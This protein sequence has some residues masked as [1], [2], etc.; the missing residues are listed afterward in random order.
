M[1]FSLHIYRKHNHTMKLTNIKDAYGAKFKVFPRKLKPM[2][3]GL[4]DYLAPTNQTLQ[5]VDVAG[6]GDC[7]AHVLGIASFFVLHQIRDFREIREAICVSLNQCDT[8]TEQ[9]RAQHCAYVPNKW[10]SESELA[11]YI[12]AV[13][14][15]NMLIITEN[16]NDKTGDLSYN[17]YLPSHV[18]DENKNFLIAYNSNGGMHWEIVV[19]RQRRTDTLTPTFTIDEIMALAGDEYMALQAQEGVYDICTQLR[20]TFEDE[21]QTGVQEIDREPKANKRK[22]GDPKTKPKRDGQA[23]DDAEG[24]ANEALQAQA[25]EGL[26]Q[27]LEEEAAERRRISAER[28]RRAESDERRRAHA[29]AERRARES[30]ERRV[31]VYAE[32]A[33]Q[34]KKKKTNRFSALNR[35]PTS[36]E[37]AAQR[38]SDEREGRRQADLEEERQRQEDEE[39]GRAQDELQRLSAE[40][41]R[42]QASVERRRAQASVERRRA[43]AALE[44][45]RQARLTK[46]QRAL[47]L[48]KLRRQMA[49]RK[50][51]LTAVVAERAAAQRAQESA[52]RRA[53]V[54]ARAARPPKKS[55]KPPRGE[56]G[57]GGGSIG[58]P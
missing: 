40:R 19:K 57:R 25:V 9:Y 44:R 56:K 10:L 36:A 16:K 2:L 42:A 30:S 11:L 5:R 49:S 45:R 48:S 24:A 13:L 21:L 54:E 55:P 47:E 1:L 22:R 35:P 3:K 37:K 26:H 12:Q 17:Y 51:A 29:S 52:A 32:R 43:E 39:E 8:L 46:T 28:K 34:T 6:D 4:N 50:L 38:L 23:A 58:L 7:G 53:Q 33:K 41:R 18:D 15:C 27:R 31:P 14:D 20:L